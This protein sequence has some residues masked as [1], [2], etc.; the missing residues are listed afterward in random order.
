MSETK[1]IDISRISSSI[2][3]ENYLLLLGFPQPSPIYRGYVPLRVVAREFYY[4]EYDP[5]QEGQILSK[6]PAGEGINGITDL[7]FVAPARLGSNY[8]TGKPFNVFQIEDKSKI[9]QLF[10]GVSPA[11]LRI[12]KEMPASTA[13][14]TLELDRWAANK[15]EFGWIDGFESPFLNPSQQSEIVIVPS[16]DFALGY[17][18]PLPFNVDPLLMFYVNHIQVA[19]VEDV[20]LVAAMLAGKVPVSIRTIGGLTTYNYPIDSV[21]GI[22]PI[23]LGA[24]TSEIATALGTANPP[25][26][27]K[28]SPGYVS[29]SLSIG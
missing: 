13:Q 8:L 1:L 7:G 20:N 26:P 17:A 2:W 23:P 27:T 6:V 22:E 29:P 5:R 15:M 18:N 12:V 28:G 25:P 10:V 11:A 9:Y 3:K 24:S 21:Y 19:V 4:F 14:N 16:I